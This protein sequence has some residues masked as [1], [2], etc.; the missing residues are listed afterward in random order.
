MTILQIED[1]IRSLRPS[2]RIAFYRWLDYMV[3]A[4][5]DVDTSFCSRLG[6]D[7]WSLEIHHAI[8]SKVAE[9]PPE[10]SR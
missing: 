2:E 3:V 8:V 1:K 4:D 10:T 5:C 7:R 6:V 9:L